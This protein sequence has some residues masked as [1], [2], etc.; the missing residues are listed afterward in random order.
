MRADSARTGSVRTESAGTDSDT[1][2]PVRARERTAHTPA[3]R[4]S[5]RLNSSH[6]QISYAVFCLKKKNTRPLHAS[7]VGSIDGPLCDGMHRIE[8]LRA[9]NVRVHQGEDTGPTTWCAHYK[10]VES[11]H[12]NA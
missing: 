10:I 9:R 2:L 12:E 4:K 7:P 5:T 3:D 8:P 1:C 6:D 11:E